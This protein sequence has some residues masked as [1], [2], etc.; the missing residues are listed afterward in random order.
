MSDWLV[1]YDPEFELFEREQEAVLDQYVRRFVART[2]HGRRAQHPTRLSATLI[3]LLSDALWNMRA[4][5]CDAALGSAILGGRIAALAESQLRFEVEGLSPECRG[6]E[7]GRQITRVVIR[8][9]GGVLLSTR[10]AGAGGPH[11]EL[12]DLC[13]HQKGKTC[14]K[15]T[16]MSPPAIRKPRASRPAL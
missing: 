11:I 1:A 9:I 5:G 10:P 14:T 3:G 2:A 12:I 8:V 4:Y 7:S 6:F 13:D 16:A 15:S